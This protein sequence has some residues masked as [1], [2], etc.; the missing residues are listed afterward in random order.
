MSLGP[1]PAR[2]LAITTLALVAGAA[3]CSAG[4][5]RGDGPLG[6]AV[7][8]SDDICNNAPAASVDGFPAYPWCNYNSGQFNVYTDNGID[9]EDT[10]PGVRTRAT[11]NASASDVAYALPTHACTRLPAG[12]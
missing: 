6:E 4:S 1:S 8:A 12:P 3:G 2:A 11:P 9:T 5:E 10:D 7:Q